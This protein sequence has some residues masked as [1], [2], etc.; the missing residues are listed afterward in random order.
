MNEQAQKTKEEFCA[1]CLMAVPLA[2]GAGGAANSSKGK[3]KKMKKTILWSSI[4]L[5]VISII[6]YII[7]KTNC[8]T[9]A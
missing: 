2:I 9:C 5:I 1:P 4:G 7:L 3:N 8:S 6:I